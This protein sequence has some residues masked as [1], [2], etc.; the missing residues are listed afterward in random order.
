ML[1]KCEK[2]PRDM[3]EKTYTVSSLGLLYR[4]VVKISAKTTQ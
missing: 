3:R 2:R 4:F 1:E